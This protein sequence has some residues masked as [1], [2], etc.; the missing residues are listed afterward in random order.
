IGEFDEITKEFLLY[1]ERVE[2]WMTV[3]STKVHDSGTDRQV[4]VFLVVIC[5]K[6][7]EMLH[8]LFMPQRP[9]EQ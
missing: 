5:T 4:R 6:A 9:S 3:N 7:Y 1:L 2:H 8:N